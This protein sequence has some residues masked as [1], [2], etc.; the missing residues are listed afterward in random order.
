[1][2][3]ENVLPAWFRVLS[4]TAGPSDYAQRITTVLNR[5]YKHGRTKMLAVAHK[6]ATPAQ[7]QALPEHESASSSSS[8]LLS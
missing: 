8:S 1:V 7:R 4:A 5:H 2:D 6:I 3:W